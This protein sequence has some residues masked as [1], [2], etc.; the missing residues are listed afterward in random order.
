MNRQSTIHTNIT[1]DRWYG[2]TDTDIDLHVFTDASKITYG[3]ACYIRVK[4]KSQLK[5]SFVMSKSKPAPVNKVS[6][7]IPQLLNYKLP[8]LHH[9]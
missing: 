9:F 8:R 1:L 4:V 2:F 6:K 5:C 3:L 7:S